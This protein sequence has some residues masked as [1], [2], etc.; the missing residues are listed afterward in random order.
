MTL[1][2]LT[3]NLRA[4]EV[5]GLTQGHIVSKK[6]RFG[7]HGLDSTSVLSTLLLYTWNAKRPVSGPEL[8]YTAC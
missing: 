6:R 8:A 4:I 3:K 1:I 2:F 7:I 5:N